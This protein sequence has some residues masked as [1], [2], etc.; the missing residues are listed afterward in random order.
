VHI[1]AGI[2]R[3]GVTK[4]AI[5]TGI[6]DAEFFIG[7]ALKPHLEPFIRSKF[8]DHRRFMQGNDPKHTSKKAKPRV[9]IC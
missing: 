6:M 7:G 2:S 5:F 8:P 3:H 1:W 4:V 9:V